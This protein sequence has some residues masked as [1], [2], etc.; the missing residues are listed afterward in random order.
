MLIMFGLFVGFVS[1]F[2]GFMKNHDSL[3]SSVLSRILR[4]VRLTMQNACWPRNR[5]GP[6]CCDQES[7]GPISTP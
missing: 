1:V 4:F 7:R 5:V 3:L 6:A 2:E